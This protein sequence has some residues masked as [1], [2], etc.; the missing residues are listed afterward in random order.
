MSE[1]EEDQTEIDKNE[2]QE[3]DILVI[4]PDDEH[5]T[6]TTADNQSNRYLFNYQYYILY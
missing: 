6:N 4:L 5:K 3:Q 2:S 1:K